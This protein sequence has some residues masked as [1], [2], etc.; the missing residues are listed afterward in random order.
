M[1]VEIINQEKDVNTVLLQRGSDEDRWFK[2][3]GF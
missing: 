3:N 2:K 1:S